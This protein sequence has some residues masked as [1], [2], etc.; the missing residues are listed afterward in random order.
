[1]NFSG[2]RNYILDRLK[3]E[4]SPDLFYH[5]L[6]HTLDIFQATTRLASLEKVDEHTLMLLQTAAL[7]HDS[8]MVSKYLDHEAESIS[9]AREALPIFDYTNNETEEVARLIYVTRL[10]QKPENLPEQIIC[11]AD[12]DS[13][14]R[15]DYFIQA[16]RL[17]LEWSIYG[18][19]N[20]TLTEWFNL[21]EKFLRE[22]NYFTIQARSIRQEQ[23]SKNILE[24]RELLSKHR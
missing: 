16:F 17:R 8:G 3:N 14:G 5:C 11:D 21:Q 20:V 2:A 19:L 23:K 1:M 22:H 12:L 4:L 6:D 15:E 7:Y 18:I 24:I 10:P 9:I 13:L